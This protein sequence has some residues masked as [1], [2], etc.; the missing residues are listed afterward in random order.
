MLLNFAVGSIVGSRLRRF[1][2]DE[3]RVSREHP[4]FVAPFAQSDMV[5]MF[6]RGLAPDL[7]DRLDDLVARSMTHELAKHGDELPKERIEKLKIAFRKALEN[8]IDGRYQRPLM[9]AVD[10]LPRR[11]LARIA[12]ALVN[13]T[14]LRRR[15]SLGEKETVGGAIDVAIL[16]KAEGFRWVKRT[17]RPVAPAGP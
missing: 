4:A 16:S 5:D 8:E 6:Y 11:D 7:N 2:L 12:E 10:A 17:G 1:Q 9:Q 3:A 13:L 15:M 14:A